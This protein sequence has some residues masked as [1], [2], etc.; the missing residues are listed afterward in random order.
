MKTKKLEVGKAMDP[1]T[2][3][4]NTCF[5]DALKEVWRAQYPTNVSVDELTDAFMKKF[6]S[7]R[8]R[9]G[10]KCHIEKLLNEDLYFWGEERIENGI[11]IAREY[12]LIEEKPNEKK[13]CHSV[14]QMCRSE[15]DGLSYIHPTDLD[16]DYYEVFKMALSAMSKHKDSKDLLEK[17][18][19]KIEDNLLGTDWEELQVVDGK[20]IIL[21]AATFLM[22]MLHAILW[23]HSSDK[24]KSTID[25]YWPRV[26]WAIEQWN[27]ES[28][29]DLDKMVPQKEMINCPLKA[30]WN[31]IKKIL[32]SIDVEQGKIS[33]PTY[34]I[35]MPDV[36][37]LF[38]F[39]KLSEA[40]DGIIYYQRLG[41]N[42]K[43][44][45]K[46]DYVL[47]SKRLILD[48]KYKFQYQDQERCA[49][50]DINR[51]L[52]YILT[53]NKSANNKYYGG[54]IYPSLEESSP[55]NM[56][57]SENIKNKRFFDKY[58]IAFPRKNNNR[59]AE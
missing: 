21:T 29:K 9:R 7:E 17:V 23:R 27:K 6:E 13:H 11:R 54:F 24:L 25:N 10:I 45:L 1:W 52:L 57:V 39:S 55:I 5:R 3:E 18:K 56:L 22:D 26:R 31:T 32:T 41:N 37:E 2:E 16:A 12:T 28:L 50:E 38:C 4:R 43:S 42:S 40:F 36:F 58:S 20:D 46:P 47:R 59:H 33:I 35:R 44:K 53:K 49:I 15:K 14:I 8:S 30:K 19:R 34:C 48:A 51:Y